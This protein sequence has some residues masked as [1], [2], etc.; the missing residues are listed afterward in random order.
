M[1]GG[2]GMTFDKIILKSYLEN[3]CMRIANKILKSKRCWRNL[4]YQVLKHF[5]ALVIKKV[6]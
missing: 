4:F 2:G 1:Q 6:Y 3:K 5:K